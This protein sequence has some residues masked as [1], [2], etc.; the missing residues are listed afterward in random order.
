V[1]IEQKNKIGTCWRSVNPEF[2]M[3]ADPLKI[4]DPP[5]A[6]ADQYRGNYLQ[7]QGICRQEQGNAE[8]SQ[9]G[10]SYEVQAAKI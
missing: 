7:E 5:D 4:P 9:R 3:P 1:S 8:Q 6:A 2:Y 10:G